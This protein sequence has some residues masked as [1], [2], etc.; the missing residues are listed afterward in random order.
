MPGGW[1]HD[2]TSAPSAQ[3][4]TSSSADVE[5]RSSRLR[6][7]PNAK[8]ATGY[9]DGGW[10]PASHDLI[11]EL[12]DLLGLVVDRIGPVERVSYHLGDWDGGPQKVGLDGR[13]VRLSGFRGQAAGTI[14]VLG[15]RHRLTLLVVPPEASAQTAQHALEAA[16]GQDNA[17]T[18]ASLLGPADGD[19]HAA[20]S[21]P[22]ERG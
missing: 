21:A 2:V 8:T 13:V 3:R 18:V 1:G 4:A 22:P 9:V 7:K 16:A 14:D 15:P 11:A 12:P 17:D 10:W 20:A 6:L 5:N 19:G